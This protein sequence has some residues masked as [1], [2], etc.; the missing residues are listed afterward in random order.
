MPGS[1]VE[2]IP[3]QTVSLDTGLDTIRPSGV[4]D[5]DSSISSP[6]LVNSKPGVLSC[7]GYDQE[8]GNLRSSSRKRFGRNIR[9]KF[10]CGFLSKEGNTH[11][12]F[13]LQN[14]CYSS[15]NYMHDEESQY[16]PKDCWE[17]GPNQLP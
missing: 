6:T 13:T 2:N 9:Q 17:A 1:R 11:L 15:F 5:T 16:N 14:S 8:L 4:A 10:M 3:S 7:M 12:N